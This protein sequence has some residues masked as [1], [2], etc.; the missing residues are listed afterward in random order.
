MNLD[1]KKLSVS[2]QVKAVNNVI[3]NDGVQYLCYLIGNGEAS[4]DV[5]GWFVLDDS[6]EGG[7]YWYDVREEISKKESANEKV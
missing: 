3:E 1:F 4:H 7:K 6:N 5:Y 2:D